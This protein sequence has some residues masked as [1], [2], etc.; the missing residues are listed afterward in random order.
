MTD[1]TLLTSAEAADIVGNVTPDAFRTWARRRGIL[2][3]RRVRVGSRTVA[4]YDPDDVF[5]ATRR[6][7]SPW[8]RKEDPS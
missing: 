7:P 1:R 8:R 5:V 4:L 6:P 2:P 3:A